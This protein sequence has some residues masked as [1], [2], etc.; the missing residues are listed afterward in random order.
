M[1]PSFLWRENARRQWTRIG[2]WGV[3]GLVRQMFSSQKDSHILKAKEHLN[4]SSETSLDQIR[5]DSHYHLAIDPLPLQQ[6]VSRNLQTTRGLVPTTISPKLLN[7]PLPLFPLCHPDQSLN[8]ASSSTLSL[9]AQPFRMS[10][11]PNYT[12][13]ILEALPVELLQEIMTLL[14]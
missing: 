4:F 14:V 3:G 9:E 11:P 13:P 7:D 10:P 12:M 6:S 5:Q 1:T 2:A 8:L